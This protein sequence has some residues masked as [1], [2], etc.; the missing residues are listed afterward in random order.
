MDLL[1]DIMLSEISQT[2][3]NIMWSHLWVDSKK[4]KKEKKTQAYR[5][6]EQTSDYQSLWVGDVQMDEDGRKEKP[7]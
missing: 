5:Y 4:R 1:E 6:R 7:F 3:T 2:K